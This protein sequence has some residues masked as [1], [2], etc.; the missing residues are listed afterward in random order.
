MRMGPVPPPNHF[1]TLFNNLVDDNVTI[2]EKYTFPKSNSRLSV[3]QNDVIF[4]PCIPALVHPLASVLSRVA[5]GALVGAG[6]GVAAHGR[7]AVDLLRGS[8]GA[9]REG[10]RVLDTVDGDLGERIAATPDPGVR[11]H[12][13][14]ARSGTRVDATR[15]QLRAGLRGVRSS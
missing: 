8:T 12:G 11:Q 1:V 14:T 13:R 2:L 10:R 5:V 3:S 15:F 4:N 9:G 7:G 6:A